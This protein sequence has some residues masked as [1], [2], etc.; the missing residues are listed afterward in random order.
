MFCVGELIIR[1]AWIDLSFVLG[2]L[3]S[4]RL[5]LIPITRLILHS[6]DVFRAQWPFREVE[7]YAS[8]AIRTADG[9]DIVRYRRPPCCFK[10]LFWK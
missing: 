2:D 4:P 9:F 7:R 5:L 6:F 3:L 1:V 10:H 8:I